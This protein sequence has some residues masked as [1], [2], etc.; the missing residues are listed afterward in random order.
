VASSRVV[1]IRMNKEMAAQFEALRH[2]FA[3]LPPST[4]ARFMVTATLALPLNEQI[5]IINNQIRRPGS[6][7]RKGSK[8][9]T[10]ARRL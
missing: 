3:G 7:P 4:I 6:Q 2:E 9:H 8:I 5:E 1:M 10:N